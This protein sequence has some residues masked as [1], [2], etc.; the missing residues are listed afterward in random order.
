MLSRINFLTIGQTPR[1]DLMPEIAAALPRSLDIVEQGALDGLEPDEVASLAPGADDQALVTRMRDGTQVVIGK[2]WLTGRIQELLDAGSR[3]P[4]EATVL[5]CT[6]DFPGLSGRRLFFD[7]Q[8]LVDHGVA[9]LSSG[10]VTLG[11]VLPL[12]RQEEETHVEPTPGQELMTA[13][14]SPYADDDFAAVGQSLSACD[15]IVMHCMGYTE[16]QREA[17]ARG[18]G[19]P[20]RLARRL[21][22][23]ALAQLL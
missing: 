3:S 18:A 23:S 22:S 19:R 10:V 7:A 2:R 6:G 15:L 21:V 12:A 1:S 9:A 16:G 14:A 11:V 5:L 8:H 4:D 13:H 17:L 20:V